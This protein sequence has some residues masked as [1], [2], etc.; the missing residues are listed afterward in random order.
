ML[1][2][3]AIEP[4]KELQ[5]VELE[6]STVLKETGRERKKNERGLE[7]IFALTAVLRWTFDIIHIDVCVFEH[8]SFTHFVQ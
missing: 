4:E 7:Y 8:F 2:I 3:F 6:E 1:S 5:V